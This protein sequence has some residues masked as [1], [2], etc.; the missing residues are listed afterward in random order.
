MDSGQ[1]F[2]LAIIAI[3]MCGGLVRFSIMARHGHAL[4][5]RRSRRMMRRGNRHPIGMMMNGMFG[6]WSDR[7]EEGDPDRDPRA[8]RKI[9]LLSSENERLTGQIGRLEER[10]RVLERIATDPAERTAR[11]IDALRNTD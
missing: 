6:G 2:V 3:S 9:E 7:Y 4:R 5:D 8:E 1:I 10:L 11:E